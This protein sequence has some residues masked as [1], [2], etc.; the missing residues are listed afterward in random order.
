MAYYIWKSYKFSAQILPLFEILSNNK[1]AFLLESGLNSN[2]PLGRYSIMGSEPFCILK[3]NSPNILAGLKEE[4]NKYKITSNSL[5]FCAGAV[6]YLAYD[7]FLNIPQYYFALYSSAIIIDHIQKRLHIF[8]TGCPEKNINAAKA[9]ARADF[10]KISGIVFTK[11]SYQLDHELS[12]T[13]R[14]NIY[15]NFTKSQYLGAIKKVKEYIRQ[16]QIYQL[17]LAQ[18][19]RATVDS[20]ALEIYRLLRKESPSYFNAFFDAGAFQI[21]SSSPER[22]LKVQYDKVFTRPMKG[23][24]PRYRDIKMDRK[25]RKELLKSEKDKAELMMIV[26]LERNDLGRVCNYNSVKVLNLRQLEEYSTVFQTTASITGRLHKDFDRI[27]LL[28]ACFPGGSITGCPKIRATEIIE[29]LEKTNR[30]IYTGSLGYLSFC[31]KMDSSI[32]IRTILKKRNKVFFG[33]GGGIVADSNPEAE[34]AETLVKA[35]AIIRSLGGIFRYGR[36]SVF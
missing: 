10:N 12:R 29:K 35:K 21:I 19:F 5:P 32:L 3:G 4:L 13:P 15:S 20:S 34:Y 26:D 27:D 8:C 28:R 7:S 31:G 22:F 24:R 14:V 9:R 30:G 16:G 2:Q 36:K 33:S 11:P 23:T 6:G 25:M 18:Q 17:N 1:G